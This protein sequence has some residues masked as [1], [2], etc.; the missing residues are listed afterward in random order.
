VRQI[1]SEGRP[2]TP[3][4]Q[5]TLAKFSG[6]GSM[7]GAF[8]PNAD[9][10]GS[11]ERESKEIASLLSPEEHDAAAKST[12]NAHYTSGPIVEGLWKAVRQ[13]GYD[14]GRMLEPS[15]GIGNVVGLMPGDLRAK[16]A[17][18][19]IELDKLT[20]M[21]ARLLYPRANI[22]VKGF[23]QF[24]VPDGFFDLAISNFPFGDY[25]VFDKD[26]AK[27]R[28]NIHDYFFLKSLDKVREGGLVVAIT[29]TG[30][31]DKLDDRV[32]TAIAARG[33]LVAA[34]RLPGSTFGKTAGTEVVTDILF[35]KKRAKD[36]PPEGAKWMNVVEVPDP[37]GGDP[38][39]VN[40]YFAA[41]PEQILG[42]LDRT[43]TMYR[44]DQ[45]NVTRPKDFEEK[46]AA[47]IARLPANVFEPAE[48]KVSAPKLSPEDMKMGGYTVNGG[49]VYRNT[50][51]GVVE[52]DTSPAKAKLIADHLLVRDA[53]RDLY[54]AQLNNADQAA[55]NAGRKK[56]NQVYDDF[57]KRN[58]PL[59][60]QSNVRAFADDPDAPTILAIEDWNPKTKTASK[61][62][63]FRQNTVRGYEKPTQ[64]A[65]T[66]AAL[67]ISLNETGGVDIER[68]A[69]LLDQSPADIGK[70]LVEKGLAFE[71]PA[72]GWESSEQYLS[73]EVRRKLLEA[74][75]AAKADKK[76]K[77]NVAALEKVQPPDME[78]ADIDVKLGV[79]WVDPGTIQTFSA[80]L[81]SGEPS[82]FEARYLP[83]TAQ[84]FFGY[85]PIGNRRHS[86]GVNDIELFGTGRASFPDI[87]GAA[88][89][90][91]FITIRDKDSDGKSYTNVEATTAANA[92]VEDL[93]ARFKDWLWQDDERRRRL[94]RTFNDTYNSVVPAKYNGAHLTFPG[95]SPK[96]SSLLY[97]HQRNAVWRTITHGTALYAHEVGTGKTATMVASAMELRR[98]G[99]AR[100]PAIAALKAN[101]E[102]IVADARELYPGAKILFVDKFD[103]QN[104]KQTIA[105]IASG[106]WDMV[107]LTHDNLNML[108][109]K[110]EVEQGF[111]Q[112]E[113][114]E[115]ESVL[116]AVED[117]E[118]G[119]SGGRRGKSDNKLVKQLEKAKARLEER[120][121]EALAG[122]RDDAVTFEET[123][124]DA[125]FVDEAHKYKSLPVYS[126]HQRI[127]GIPTSAN[128]S[129][130]A[131][132]MAMRTQW[133][134]EM[135]GG[136]GVV[137][138]TGTPIANTMAE[139]Y[140]MQRYLQ[141]LELQKRG[142]YAFDAWAS[143]F[144]TLNTRL[145]YDVVGQMKPVT[146]FSEFVNMR[147][148]KQMASQMMDVQRA[149]KMPNFQRPTRKDEAHAVP[150]TDEQRAYL[151]ALRQR[152]EA[153]KRKRPG[154][155]G[156]NMLSI[157][158]D[159]RKS[160]LDMRM[161][162]PDAQDDPNSKLAKAVD[163]VLA[164]HKEHPG[165]TQ[166]I[167]LDLGVH[168]TAWD[169]SAY[170]EIIRRLEEG[171]IP[172]DKIIDFGNLTDAKKRGAVARLNSGDA[173]V[174][175]GGSDKMGTGVNAQK[176][177]IALHHLDAPWK[178]SDLEQRDG[179][180]W[181]KGNTNK[182][183]QIH[184]YV[185]KGS[186]DTFMWQTVTAKHRFI[187]AFMDSDEFANK[188]KEDGEEGEMSYSQV[189]AIA[190][191]K[192]ALIEKVNVERDVQNLEAAARRH[193]QSQY[194]LRDTVA[195]LEKFITSDKS[196][197]EGFKADL[198]TSE[199]AGDDFSLTLGGKTYDNR[200]DAAQAIKD[201]TPKLYAHAEP[202]KVGE[203]RGLDIYAGA[204]ENGE[205]ARIVGQETHNATWTLGGLEHAARPSTIQAKLTDRTETLK[206]R[207]KDLLQAKDQVGAEFGKGAELQRKRQR[208]S[209]LSDKVSDKPVP[210]PSG[211]TV[212]QSMR[213]A[214]KEGKSLAE[215]KSENQATL[216]QVDQAD[217]LFQH[218][219]T[220]EPAVD[221]LGK[222]IDTA[223]I[224]ALPINEEPGFLRPE[225]EETP[226]ETP[227]EKKT[228][229]GF[230]RGRRSG[231]VYTGWV[232]HPIKATVAVGQM[233]KQL[234][235][236]YSRPLLE[237]VA[238]KGGMVGKQI[239][240]QSRHA[241]DYAREVVG[242]LNPKMVKALHFVSGRNKAG[243]RAVRELRQV[244]MV[245]TP[246][247]N[248]GYSA[249]Q[250]AVED[251]TPPGLTKL[252]TSPQADQAVQNHRD[253]V[254]ATGAIA[255]RDGWKTQGKG[256]VKPFVPAADGKRVMR[257][258]TT[259]GFDLASR[260]D[261]D[262]MKIAWAKALGHAN[263]RP[264][265]D[266][267]REINDAFDPTVKQYAAENLRS[268]KYV[269]THV[270]HPDTGKLIQIMHSEPFDA[271]V[272][273][274][275]NF[276]LRAG[277]IKHFGQDLPGDH[278]TQDM[279]D[280]YRKAGGKKEQLEDLIRALHGVPLDPMH[281]FAPGTPAYELV[282]TVRG[283]N[284][285]AKAG[286]LT[287]ATVPNL[288][289]T[290]TKTLS[291]V[292]GKDY[293][294]AW[295]MLLRH[296][297]L[298]AHATA[299]L[300]ARTVDIHNWMGRQ[301]HLVEAM[302]K[303]I[304]SLM[305]APLRIANELNELQSAVAGVKF[306]MDLPNS[307]TGSRDAA[308]L[309]LL[310]Y[311]EDEIADLTSATPDP[312]LLKMVPARIAEQTQGTTSRPSELPK[313]GHSAIFRFIMPFQAWPAMTLN[314]IAKMVSKIVAP[315]I[316]PKQRVAHTRILSNFLFGS[317]IAGALATFLLAY[318][319][320][321]KNEVVVR[322]NEAKDSPGRFTY[323]A[324]KFSVLGGLA[325][326]SAE[327]VF[328]NHTTS[329]TAPFLGVSMP[330][331][332]L[333][334]AYQM[335]RGVGKYK[336]LT[337]L[338][339]SA[340]FFSRRLAMTPS[341]STAMAALGLSDKNQK[342]DVAMRAFYRWR[343]HNPPEKGEGGP[344]VSG[345]A[346]ETFKFV[347]AMRKFHEA[348]IRGDDKA[349]MDAL[350][351]GLDVKA[352]TL[353]GP[354]AKSAIANSIRSHKLLEHLSDEEFA[355]VHKHIGDD[356]FHELEDYDLVLESWARTIH[357]K[358]QR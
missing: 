308:T 264:W 340:E 270:E 189:M 91:T 99:L 161:V 41:H 294:R 328:D 36:T 234:L 17:V 326:T 125:L 334:E 347:R 173:W 33:D 66:G 206:Q 280:A 92:K 302:V 18:T 15:M 21:I 233:A 104:R 245:H 279:I 13:L 238:A 240:T 214:I 348:S 252:R 284:T 148:L 221:L 356:A 20:G 317:A 338:E 241:N 250:S 22:Q 100:K 142:V 320:G 32:R 209:Y 282:R 24:H 259:E 253:L 150:M 177:L 98:L 140:T 69:S 27:Y 160:A 143:T 205:R 138:A 54:T 26:Y 101:I 70:E 84:W 45:K 190:S 290:L 11:W 195:S 295:A 213:K 87:M 343:L 191:G 121:H 272:A 312:N 188:L 345:P 346:G 355:A 82:H 329:L 303:N 74:Q 166:M 342:L 97:P 278:P 298:A 203:L 339:K 108:P 134:Q 332:V 246:D 251:Q 330:I 112:R 247:V 267:M 77:P 358:V 286:A 7:P 256:G 180:G 186:F 130:R 220:G 10:A 71:N 124:I 354:K 58:G 249:F 139:M 204:D 149:N 257:S 78:A 225:E 202:I 184:R 76:Y 211:E 19:G 268:L 153:A 181:R 129:D 38:I 83:A 271:A 1:S 93:Q 239:G 207:E 232:E 5:Q 123:G 200:A 59:H 201:Y 62:D 119:H 9:R 34:I 165:K 182:Q 31:M 299:D 193:T 128:R 344:D 322:W 103:A 219:A 174:G 88:L 48:R 292:G 53:L 114:D 80:E 229:R 43:G 222:P 242:E 351:D 218:L 263:S 275:R 237:S 289:E 335:A 288:F 155:K 230:G 254:K 198:A 170:N 171:G 159:G 216:P 277:Y 244:Q 102:G 291:M 314:R 223:K 176:L 262:P 261:T 217:E 122:K 152:A 357:P 110:K 81:F 67:G 192:P 68:I 154:E 57:V 210:H 325:T 273:M 310:G 281:W 167:F 293:V 145:E 14:K 79:P 224:E 313:S 269:P 113:I 89:N 61:A 146:R 90:G 144:G 72:G 30:T 260:P 172:R 183:V 236:W 337:T 336:G 111:I 16:S 266:M 258:I 126:K 349:S 341:M 51:Q 115:L 231:A 46:F 276:S 135:Q 175:L 164:I 94:T 309:R 265:A 157:S 212:G 25:R 28:A 208:L 301:G 296:P 248:Y 29:S 47:A 162:D 196:R 49:K 151:Q 158:M 64:A 243:R 136:R 65:D 321:G 255:V 350:M 274:V 300:G 169:F 319:K 226:E 55:T 199:A 297:V 179:R 86:G 96:W 318:L 324:Y 44:G 178:P 316:S 106:D 116:R 187:N 127:K 133:L 194:K 137:F 333:E 287:M 4:E 42:T 147:G 163:K 39:P 12:L 2:A 3:E 132:M 215:W 37:G 323:D 315:G 95:M 8:N 63:V 6:W 304:S 50:K 105:R 168:P 228:G 109:M 331:S 117:E 197:I 131:T 60:T 305:T 52:I 311:T 40:E 352:E 75:D 141:P 285:L 235:D 85:S 327:A 306:A 23:E 35:L 185:T 156:D 307:G 56:L 283:F 120:L 227:G 73:G 118:A 353:N 107:I